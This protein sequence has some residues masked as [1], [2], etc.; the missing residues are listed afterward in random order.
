[1]LSRAPPAAMDEILIAVLVL[2]FV[3]VVAAAVVTLV[4]LLVRTSALARRLGD[5]EGEL[6][7][8][9]GRVA[10]STTPAPVAPHEPIATP[11]VAQPKPSIVEPARPELASAPSRVEPVPIA[12]PVTSTP[13]SV[14]PASTVLPPR[15]PPPPRVER[16][17]D[18]PRVPLEKLLGVTGAAILGGIVLAIAGFYLYQ[19]SVQQGWVT[20]EVRLALGIA[21]GLACI[22]A[23]V[24]LRARYA[25]TSDSLAGGGVVVLYAA[26]WAGHELFGVWPAW[27]SFAAMGATTAAC[28][29][30][31]YRRSSQVIAAL[32]LIGGFATPLVLSTGHDRPIGLFGYTLLVNLGFL[33]VA[34]RRRWPALGSIA[35]LGTF[36]IEA[37]WI[38]FR[39]SGETYGIA[40]VVLPIFALLFGAFAV[41]QAPNGR[42]SSTTTLVGAIAM[43]FTFAVYFAARQD[44]VVGYHL[45]PM[46]A[47][48]G[49]V[50]AAGGWLA[51]K[52][53][54]AFVPLGAAVGSAAVVLAWTASR[55]LDGAR[56]WELA[57]C[58][59]GLALVQHAH[60]EL[61]RRKLG[62]VAQEAFVASAALVLG[63][64]AALFVEACSD[65]APAFTP[66]FV[67]S[68]SLVALS[69][70]LASIARREWFAWASAIPVGLVL[71]AWAHSTNV[72]L[73]WTLGDPPLVW[74]IALA[75]VPFLACFLRRDAE[76]RRSL[77]HASLFLLA[78]GAVAFLLRV[79]A[80]RALR[81]EAIASIVL[82][83]LPVPAIAR[84]TGVAGRSAWTALGALYAAGGAMAHLR[85]L[86][87]L[88]GNRVAHAEA[89][90]LVLA[91]AAVFAG[92]VGRRELVPSVV[93]RVRAICVLL[94]V[95]PARAAWDGWTLQEWRGVPVLVLAAIAFAAWRWT[96]SASSV[97]VPGDA[98]DA[99]GA[100]DARIARVWSTSVAIVLALAAV[101]LEV[102]REPAL[103]AAG[104]AGG[105]LAWIARRERH[106]P[107]AI[108]ATALVVIATIGLTLGH[109]G[110][111]FAVQELAFLNELAWIYLAPA[112]AAIA[113]A[114][115][116][117]K[118]RE[119][120]GTDAWT[121]RW[122]AT[123]CGVAA[124]VLIF[125][126]LNLAILD[127]FGTTPSM[128][129]QT[130]RVPTRDLTLS[131][132]W[133]VYALVLLVLGVTRS[134]SGLR[135]ISLALFLVTIA[136]VFLV[137]LG[138]LTGLYRVGSLFGL[139]LALLA[140]SLLYQRF[141]FRRAASEP[142]APGPDAA[143]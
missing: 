94:F 90:A 70:R 35:L 2:A 24:P 32:G 124:V 71:V 47:L 8:L 58:C 76:A 122:S 89:F 139:A 19:Y 96:S 4:V 55:K 34:H 131:I 116:L 83:T 120:N 91:S 123:T 117:G 20:K 135:W 121:W 17:P 43:P 5:V 67:A 7:R 113:A 1:M 63:L 99:R 46:A 39:S 141:V 119:E 10:S 88:D 74:S 133:A 104:L 27:V 95:F 79:N 9:R 25:I 54:N 108:L 138:H 26:F 105:G 85:D 51:R 14:T 44:P 129:W 84:L 86:T 21:T 142:I 111:A 45:Y 68:A 130:E 103:V 40:L 15:P 78:A 18:R 33:S 98:L 110:H 11:L 49:V 134:A 56:V 6:A 125:A 136:K 100:H 57:A 77:A 106:A 61:V 38:V 22:A 69:A 93:A 101:A 48:A 109:V 82:L 140:V 114:R 13:A 52:Q 16:A 53:G 81:G 72:P 128:R 75:I 12:P 73:G 29:A 126:W 97:V 112:A 23:S 107:L 115:F 87:G 127:A 132:A 50:V 60:A 59:V 102:D 28:C 118:L 36:V 3:G 65:N 62:V 137:D 41:L 80:P 66:W 143:T 92:L 64:L 31:A 30:L 42:A 37:A